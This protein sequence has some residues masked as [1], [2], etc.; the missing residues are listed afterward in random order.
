[1]PRGVAIPDAKEELFSATDRLLVREGPEGLTSRAITDEAGC[2]KGVLHNHF[3]DLD[4]FLVEYALDRLSRSTERAA[5]L[6]ERAGTGTV[7]ANLTAAAV[8]LFGP[9]T[10]GL[11]SLLVSRPS[12]LAEAQR[13]GPGRS[14]FSNVELTFA[15]YLGAEKDLGRLPAQADVEMM[16]FTLLGVVHHVFF[17]SGLRPLEP[18]QVRRVV[19]SIVGGLALQGGGPT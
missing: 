5:M 6:R 19:A 8:E 1:M 15:E 3:G 9:S 13:S 2:A 16:A 17:T 10:L 14:A 7:E 4:H 18:V 11:S 12:L